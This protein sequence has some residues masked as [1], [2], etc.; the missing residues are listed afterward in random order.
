VRIPTL[1][2]HSQNLVSADVFTANVAC[3]I[4]RAL[5]FGDKIDVGYCN[6]L[7]HLISKQNKEEACSGFA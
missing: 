2:T 7:H 3:L 4:H 5:C 1:P 6:R